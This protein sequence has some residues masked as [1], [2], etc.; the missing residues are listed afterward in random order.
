MKKLPPGLE[1]SNILVGEVDLPTHPIVT[2]V[3]LAKVMYPGGPDGG[4][5]PHSL[6]LDHAWTHWTP[7]EVP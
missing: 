2:F 5:H 3:C 4:S 1:A 7:G 6:Q